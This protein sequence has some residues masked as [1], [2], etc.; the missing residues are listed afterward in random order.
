MNEL[1]DKKSKSLT[2]LFKSLDQKIDTMSIN[3]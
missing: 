1:G 2:A 3:F